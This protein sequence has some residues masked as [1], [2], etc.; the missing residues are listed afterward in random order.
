MMGMTLSRRTPSEGI[1]G[2]ETPSFRRT[3]KLTII[4]QDPGFRR[5]GNVE[6]SAFYS[7]GDGSPLFGYFAGQRSKKT[8]FTCLSRDMRERDRCQVIGQF[9]TFCSEAAEH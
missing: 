9:V 4:A 7:R 2:D 5:R 6:A 8:V 1:S 3:R